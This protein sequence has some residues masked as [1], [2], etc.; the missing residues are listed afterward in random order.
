MIEIKVN[1]GNSEFSGEG[2][3]IELIQDC[4]TIVRTLSAHLAT[5]SE[6][7]AEI[8]EHILTKEIKDGTFFD[9]EKEENIVVGKLSDF[10]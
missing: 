9:D 8:Y 6:D 3:G 10:I 2:K 7:L 5:E 1:K 4:L